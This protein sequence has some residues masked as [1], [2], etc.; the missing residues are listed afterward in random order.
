MDERAVLDSETWEKVERVYHT[1]LTL[2]EGARAAYVSQ[3]CAGDTVLLEEVASLLDAARDSGSF[4]REPV[5]D[6]GLRVLADERAWPADEPGGSDA[7]RGDELIGATLDHRYEITE[8]L[9]GGGMGDVYKAR[10]RK[11]LNRPVVVKVLKA[12][13]SE[14]EWLVSKFKQEIEASNKIDHP[15]VVSFFDAGQLPDGKP[16]LVMQYV[17]GRDLRK[18]IPPERGMPLDEVAEVVR[19]VGRTLNIA[20]E[21]GVIHR[22]MKPENIMFRRDENGDIQVKIIDFGIAKIKDSMVAASTS[23]GLFIG[24]PFYMSPEQL[25]PQRPYERNAAG[26]SDIYAFGVIAYE[27]VTGRRPFNA[28]TPVQMAALQKEGVK[29]LPCDLRPALPEAAQRAI[30][31]ALSYHPAERYLSARDFCDDLSRALLAG[32]EPAPPPA[33]APTPAVLAE[34][35]TVERPRASKKKW[36]AAAVALPL[37]ALALLAAGLWA[38]RRA[39]GP[40]RTLSY[41]LRVQKMRDGKPYEQPFLSSGTEIY[42][43]GYKFQ[44]LMNAQD[45]GYVYLFDEGKD[46]SGRPVFNILFP[47]PKRNGGSAQ[48]AAAASLETG[49]NTFGGQTGTESV[50]FVWTATRHAELEE[51]RASALGDEKGRVADEAAAS[52]LRTFLNREG[53]APAE[54]AKDAQQQR[55]IL[56]GRGDVLLYPLALEYR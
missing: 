40:E 54:A 6:H 25:N 19:Q 39:P 42:E 28:E 10:D 12:A 2:E 50:W 18:A 13:A 26:A 8:R 52:R 21:K 37:L 48:V 27:M 38:A 35:V 31:K 17:E 20:H 22:D 15:G 23:T 5:F 41:S 32:A 9:G 4:L 30:L 33:P 1:A 53:G 34:T 14:S 7:G 3:A 47:T 56:R 55:T 29:V 11:L 24:T 51:A 49:W 16:Y 43:K 44:V 46:E 45:E 36:L